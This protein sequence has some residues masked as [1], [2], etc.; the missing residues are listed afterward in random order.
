M[1]LASHVIITAYGF[2]LPNEERGSW[3][4]FVRNWELL[5]FGKATKVETTRSVAHR[6]YDRELR[7]TMRNSLQYPP[8]KFTGK[9]ALCIAMAFAEQI[10]KSG[11]MIYACA[12]LPEHTHYV[13]GRHRY[14]VDQVTNLLKGAATRNLTRF[15]MHP[16]QDF[17]QSGKKLSSPWAS[18]LWKVFLDSH[19]DICRSI[20]Y[21]NANPTK[22][23]KKKQV[24]D[25]VTPY[26][27]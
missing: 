11:F 3:S 2:W 17:V 26:L 13:V 6:P 25:F 12:I 9:Q 27:D 5:R 15:G 24:W 23:G 19:A 7:R 22:E 4:D 14:H 10:K 20:D 21:V 8:V 16:M 1:I 18:G